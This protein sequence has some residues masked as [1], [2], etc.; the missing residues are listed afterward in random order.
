M[1]GI[2]IEG[3]EKYFGRLRVIHGIDLTID[4]GQF[5]VILGP[6]G[7][8]KSTLLRMIAGLERI[9]AGTISIGGILMNA[10]AAKDRGCAMVFQDYALYPHMNVRKNMGYGLRLAR[11]PAGERER[12]VVEAARMLELEHYLDRKPHELSGGQRQ[13]VA[14]GRAIAREPEVF[15]FDEPLSNLDA[16]LRMDTRVELRKLH[17]RLGATSVFVTH[18]QVE[19]MT[20]ADLLIVM[21][22][23]R[24]EQVGSP[25]EVYRKPASTF[26]AGFIGSPPVNLLA[27]EWSVEMRSYSP[28]NGISFDLPDVLRLPRPPENVVLGIRPEDIKLSG[29]D[30]FPVTV[31]YIEDLGAAFTVHGLIGRQRIV[32]TLASCAQVARGNVV[33]VRFPASRIHLFDTASGKRL[34]L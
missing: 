3:V 22:A 23:G 11:V 5:A 1:A 25:Q 2:R 28:G 14:I 17:D 19:A 21:N 4:H 12:R 18:D 26:V 29:K 33:H 16:K 34:P 13:R 10:V 31:D 7:C 27:L 20:L 8:G 9:S 32:L 24:I 30:G 6:S 15:L